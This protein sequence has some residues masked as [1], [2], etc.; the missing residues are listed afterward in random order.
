LG[1]LR[2]KSEDTR[3]F[4]VNVT[5]LALRELPTRSNCTTIKGS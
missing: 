3:Q 1:K 4:T 5:R 2:E